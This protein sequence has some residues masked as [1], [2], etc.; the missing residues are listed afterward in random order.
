MKTLRTEKLI[1]KVSGNEKPSAK[2]FNVVKIKLNGMKKSFVIEAVVV[3]QI[4][5]PITNQMVTRVSQNYPYLKNLRLAD[6]FNEQLINIHIL[7]GT[8]F[9][10][11]FFTDEIIRDKSNEPVALSSHCGWVLKVNQS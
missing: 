5:S 11:T 3:S 2:L 9:Y 6:S 10:H 7:I 1:L 4:C 8:Y